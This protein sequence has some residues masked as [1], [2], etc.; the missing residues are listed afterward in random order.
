MVN[1]VVRLASKAAS[2]VERD[3]VHMC[4]EPLEGGG[5]WGR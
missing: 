2:G 5:G 3:E 1:G 4:L